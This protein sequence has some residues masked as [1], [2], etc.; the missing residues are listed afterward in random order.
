MRQV[1][2]DGF[3]F[4]WI[5]QS[6]DDVYPR[7]DKTS[8]RLYELYGLFSE[9]IETRYSYSI[10]LQQCELTNVNIIPVS[11]FGDDF[12]DM[13]RAFV[14]DPFLWDVPGLVAETYVRRRQHKIVRAD[15]LPVGRLHS[16]I[17]PVFRNDTS[18]KAFQFELTA[19]SAQSLITIDSAKEF[20]DH[21]HHLINSR[22]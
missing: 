7:Y 10:E 11:S 6:N 17:S 22:S 21:A 8:A 5:K 13:S 19:R 9:F 2:D 3:G 18:E 15:G 1:Q 4:N 14:V 16:A 12:S 20:F